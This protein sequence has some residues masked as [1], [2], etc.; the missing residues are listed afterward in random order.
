MAMKAVLDWMKAHGKYAMQVTF[1]CFDEENYRL[2]KE[3][4]DG[5]K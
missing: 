5:M 4:L 1:A 3:K 2:Y